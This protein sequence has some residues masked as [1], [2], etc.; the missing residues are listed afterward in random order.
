M[1]VLAPPSPFKGLAAFEDTDLDALFFCGREREREVVVANLLASRLTVLYGPS[2]VGKT[3]LLRAAVAHSLR[4]AHHAVVIVFS[5]WAGDPRAGLAEAIDASAGIESS[6]TLSER[7]RAVGEAHV[8]LDQFEEYFL[9]HEAGAFADELADAIADPGLR[10]NFLLGLREDALAKLDAF[11]GR[12]PNLFANYLRLDHLERAGARAAILGPIE[13]YNELTGQNVRVEPGLVDAVLDQVAAGRVD[14]GTAGRGGI[15]SDAERIEAP[16]LQLVLERLWEAEQERKSTVLRLST[17]RELGGAEAIVRGHL[18]Q[19][20]GRLGPAEQDVAATMFAQLVTP[21]GSK[22]AHRPG[23]LAQYAHVPEAEVRPVLDVLGQERIVRAVDGAG[24]GERYEIFHDVLADGVLAWRARREL[25]RDREQAHARQRRLA[26]VA[27]AALLA[28]VAMTAVAIYAFTERSHA[29]SSARQARARALEATALA[30]LPTDPQRALAAA[31]R[32]VRLSPSDRAAEVLRQALVQSHVRRVLDAP[33]P[34]TAV[35]FAGHGGELLAASNRGTRIYSADGTVVR[36]LPG[37]A[38]FSPNGKPV[39]GAVSISKDGGLILETSPAGATI[40]RAATGRKVAALGPEPVVAGTFSPDGRLVAAIGGG[41]GEVTIFDVRTGRP[42]HVL[43]RHDV[44]SVR[45]SPDGKL[46]A[47][48]DHRGIDLWSPQSGRHVDLLDDGAPTKLMNDCEF[49]S[50][51]KLLAAAG[52]DGAVRIWD[53]ARHWRRFYFTEHTNPLFAVAWSPDGRF[54]ADASGD[55]SSFVWEVRGT[56]HG[57]RVAAL[58]GDTSAVTSVAFSPDGASVLTGS[59]DGT[60]RLWDTRFEQDLQPLGRLRGGAAT[61][62]FGDGGRLV[63]AAGADGARVWNVH[64][65]RLLH[66]LRGERLNDAEFSPD[67]SRIVTAG[68]DSTGRIIDVRSGN[69]RASLQ[70]PAPLLVSRFS[71]DGATIVLG[72]ATGHVWLWRGG[73][74]R[75]ETLQQTGPVEDAAFAPDGKSVATAGRDGA[76]IWPVPSGHR[77]RL[78]ESPRGVSRVRF[79]PDGSLIAAAGY[80]GAARIWDASSGKR[81]KVLAASK[82]ALTDVAFSPDGRLLLTTGAGLRNNVETWFVGTGRPLHVLV[83]HF[84][85]VAGG[86][87][88]PDGRWIVTAGPISAGLWQSGADH[89]YFYLRGGDTKLAGLTAVSFSPDGRLVLSASEDGSVRLYRCEVCGNLQQLV[90][91]AERRLAASR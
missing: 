66:T 75:P 42:L 48:A 52:Q 76:S 28:L 19:A 89:P 65:R 21:S 72:D 1:S 82:L 47:T 61:A 40:R 33:G 80:D 3:S 46:L 44:K 70:A 90:A 91:L 29:R 78:L 85:S 71:P 24:G 77:I 59:A 57:Q 39:A 20:L 6:G 60:A 18:E 13:R 74:G 53:I 22:I 79:S 45:F 68:S 58:T 17:L 67:G 49:S 23:D 27:A 81:L 31:V 35:S 26:F 7:L 10:A 87:F 54:V 9:Y 50:D 69:N 15:E 37:K 5:S 4:S 84:G 36:T 86:A 55:R 30:E 8:I 41:L 88:S 14:V 64:T 12:I 83:G 25:E 2:G 32:A 73:P 63:I 34:V 51:G 62:S 11:K 16:Y 56:A 43:R 38:S